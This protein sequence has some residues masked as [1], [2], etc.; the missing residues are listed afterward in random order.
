MRIGEAGAQG[1]CDAA[2]AKGYELWAAVLKP[3]LK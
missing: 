1:D 3:Y 2:F